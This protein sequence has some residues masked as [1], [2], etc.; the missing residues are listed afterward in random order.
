VT[1][2]LG[3]TIFLIGLSASATGPYRGI[4]AIDGLHFSNS[5]FA[6][7]AL[8]SSIGTAIISLL[9][10]HLID[11][12]GDRR[13][14]VLACAAFSGL[15]YGLIFYAPSQLTFVVA[16]CGILPFGGALFSQTFSFSRAF[17][18]RSRPG[19]AEF[20]MSALRTLFSLAFVVAPALVGWLAAHYS[21]YGV[22]GAAAGAQLAILVVFSTLF[23][24]P[25]TKIGSAQASSGAVR[26][27]VR[28]PF[29]RVV[30]I[31]GVMLLRAGIF[32]H[33]MALPLVLTNQFGASLADVGFNAGACAVLEIPFMLM[34]GHLAGRYSK[35]PII[36]AGALIYALYLVAIPFARS[37]QDVLWLQGPNAVGTAALVSLPIAYMQESVKGRIGLSTALFDVV[38]VVGQMVASVVFALCATNASYL[39]V[40]LAT[41]AVSVL[42]GAAVGVSKPLAAGRARVAAT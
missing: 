28:M 15:A 3:A 31:F 1:P 42:G 39:A 2:I 17:Y 8:A 6:A 26:A 37:V 5:A 7:I 12:A 38:T 21:I 19:R 4:V 18:D 25:G 14:G 30:G 27:G 24:V 10:G 29:G 35:E 36:V 16:F 13:L 33:M 20:M 34:W 22:F 32:L 9:L 40:L 11:S 41:A 23:L